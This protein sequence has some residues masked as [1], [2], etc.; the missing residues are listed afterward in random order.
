M[1]REKIITIRYYSHQDNKLNS[2]FLKIGSTYFKINKI[3]ALGPTNTNYSESA[4]F[5]TDGKV[6]D[7]ICDG[8]KYRVIVPDDSIEKVYAKIA[9]MVFKEPEKKEKRYI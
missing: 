8:V 9:N 6:F 5:E 2:N 3:S 7:L 1:S 4:T